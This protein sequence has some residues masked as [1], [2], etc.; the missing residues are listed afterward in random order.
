MVQCSGMDCT[1]SCTEFEFAYHA[2]AEGGIT[3]GATSADRQWWGTIEWSN[4]DCTGDVKHAMLTRTGSENCYRGQYIRVGEVR[5]AD[6][7]FPTPLPSVATA[8]YAFACESANNRVALIQ[9]FPP[10]VCNGG[11]QFDLIADGMRVRAHDHEDCERAVVD[12]FT[13]TPA[14]YNQCWLWELQETSTTLTT[15]H[16]AF[17]TKDS[18]QAKE[19]VHYELLWGNGSSPPPGPSNPEP[20]GPATGTGLSPPPPPDEPPTNA[21]PRPQLPVDAFAGA[22]C[23][24]GGYV[25][26]DIL[27][28]SGSPCANGRLFCTSTRQHIT[29]GYI[30]DNCSAPLYRTSITVPGGVSQ[31]GQMECNSTAA[32]TTFGSPLGCS[33]SD[34]V[35]AVAGLRSGWTTY[36]NAECADDGEAAGGRRREMRT[37]MTTGCSHAG[38]WPSGDGNHQQSWQFDCAPGGIVSLQFSNRS[39]DCS[40]AT[41]RADTWPLHQEGA[42]VPDLRRPHVWHRVSCQQAVAADGGD[43][44][45]TGG[46]NT[47]GDVNDRQGSATAAV[48]VTPL[49]L[50]ALGWLA[51]QAAAPL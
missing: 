21:P 44:T 7:R 36:N 48:T 24:G 3:V 11:L 12:D 18:A 29:N 25:V 40:A 23:I 42:C 19:F 30:N 47:D 4:A 50:A 1:G 31:Y 26:Y 33:G 49:L 35:P 17:V 6:I 45:V 10:N 5:A 16:I 27:D 28:G 15:Y 34:A 20:S 39:A 32:G 14:E 22:E 8:Q 38:R 41:L 46:S 2:C 43:G 13:V 9:A 37:L 51:G